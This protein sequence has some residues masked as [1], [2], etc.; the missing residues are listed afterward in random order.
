MPPCSEDQ[1][2]HES[3]ESPFYAFS[4]GSAA[5]ECSRWKLW[6]SWGAS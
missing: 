3:L 2:V 4:K 6:R 5:Q 1:D